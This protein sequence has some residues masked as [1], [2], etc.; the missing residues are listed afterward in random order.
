MTFSIVAFDSA[1]GVGGIAITTARPGIGARSI[2][3]RPGVGV[4]AT[5]AIVNTAL[6]HAVLDELS[7]GKAP[8][9][10]INA[11]T[12]GDNDAARRQLAVVDF[13]G[14]VAT[15]TGDG[16]SSWC[17]DRCAGSVAV[18]GNLLT[19]PEVLDATLA[20]FQ[21]SCGDLADRLLAAL[22]A[23]QDA[24]GDRR[25]RE[26]AA[27]MVVGEQAW[28]L[29]DLRVD[30]DADPSDRLAELLELWRYTW[31]H[32]DETGTFLPADPPGPP[33]APRQATS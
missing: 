4:V 24:G 22:R 18:A 5:Q 1:A 21:S 20:A 6:G 2:A 33:P 9:E 31:E 12:A 30:H 16:V 27:L 11:A 15:C 10:A 23:G 8:D 29:V 7:A 32:Y 17:G 26:S 25:G 14:R 3:V 13:R 19:G 28:P